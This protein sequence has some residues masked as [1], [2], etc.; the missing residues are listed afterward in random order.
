MKHGSQADALRIAREGKDLT[1]SQAAERFD[2]GL[3]TWRSYEHGRRL[4][5]DGLR[6][7][8]AVAWDLDLPKLCPC[9]G[10]VVPALGKKKREKKSVLAS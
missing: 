9:C 7:K 8:V 3:D 6:R 10:Q 4:L 5:P 2:V 1:Q